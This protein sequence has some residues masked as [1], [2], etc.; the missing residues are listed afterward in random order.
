MQSLWFTQRSFL[1]RKSPDHWLLNTSPK[2]I[3]ATPRPSSLVM[4]LGIHHTPLCTLCTNSAISWSFEIA[5][6]RGA[7]PKLYKTLYCEEE[8]RWNRDNFKAPARYGNFLC[9]L[10]CSSLMYLRI[11]YAPHALSLK[12][13]CSYHELW[14]LCRG[15]YFRFSAKMRLTGHVSALRAP[16]GRIYFTFISRIHLSNIHRFFQ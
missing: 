3:A 2:L 10:R 13:N 14:H 15:C 8:Q 12:E 7:T 9:W 5:R 11:H 4:C 1:I 6:V 16:I